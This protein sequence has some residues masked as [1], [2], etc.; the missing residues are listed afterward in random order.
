MT[1]SV[2]VIGFSAIYGFVLV[3]EISRL[4][5]GNSVRNILMSLFAGFGF[6]AHSAYIAHQQLAIGSGQLVNNVQDFFF[7]AAWGLVV[8]Y[9]YLSY[10]FPKTPFGLVLLPLTLLLIAGGMS[11]G[12]PEPFTV[13]HLS[14]VQTFW[15]L[16]HGIAFLG[17]TL[18][19][20]SGFVF[21]VLYILHEYRLKRKTP[22]HG[23]RFRWPSLEWL[24]GAAY[25]CIGLSIVFIGVG[26][27]S[28]LL[29]N[30][31]MEGSISPFTP[32]IVGIILQFVFLLI[33]FGLFAFR[34]VTREPRR[35]VLLTLASF[36]F[37]IAIL[38][39]GLLFKDSHWHHRVDYRLK[40]VGYRL[41]A[42]DSMT[43]FPRVLSRFQ[44]TAYRLQPTA[45]SLHGGGR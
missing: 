15:R 18:S 41:E 29:T 37:L 22:A 17:A 33:F 45:Y 40:A 28:G 36:L 5:F 31:L 21:G 7:V 24:A 19:V 10:S 42:Q 30:Q 2:G 27:F 3:L 4:Y 34:P 9:L 8:V 11:L 38:L 43:P 13:E 1:I 12:D 35:I 14:A 16:L 26:I 6:A 32:M 39:C 25:Q 20:L 23:D 44:S